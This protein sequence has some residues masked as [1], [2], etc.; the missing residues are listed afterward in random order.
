MR[1]VRPRAGGITRRA[2]ATLVAGS[3]F[4][5]HKGQVLP[6]DGSRFPDPATEFPI[7]RLTNPSYSSF[8]PSPPRRVVSHHGDFLI[9]VSDRL[10]SPQAF[11]LDLKSGDW[12]QLTEM[13]NLDRETVSLLPGDHTLCLMDGPDLKL[14]RFAGAG[15]K[16]RQIYSIED[17]WARSGGVAVTD[18]GM[19]ALLVETKA[20]ASRLRLIPFR[21]GAPVTLAEENAVIEDVLPRPRRTGASYRKRGEAGVRLADFEGRTY[22]LQMAD[23]KVGDD[24]WSPDGRSLFYLQIPAERG[25]L[26]NIREFNPDAHTDT[27]IAP[28]TQ[29]AVFSRNSD[30]S[31]FVGASGSKASPHVL[32]LLRVTKREL[33]LAEH[34]ASDPLMVAPVFS[35]SN[36]RVYFTTD[37]DGKPCVHWMSVEKLVETSES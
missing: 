7:N 14:A 25:K 2:F 16:E 36:D 9:L 8:L 4:G 23:G 3:A 17:G 29:F 34:K 1:P 12:H 21:K 31:V 15:I 35:P 13:E 24:L 22:R 19:F 32:L 18:D 26:I 28:T 5:A 6:P 30:A 10:G 33:T 27:A 37:R 11:R 20:G